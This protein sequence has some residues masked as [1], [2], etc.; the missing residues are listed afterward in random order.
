M[1]LDPNDPIVET[2]VFGKEVENFLGGNIGRYLVERAEKQAEE[3]TDLLKKVSPWRRRRIQQLQNRIAVA[4]SVQQWLA[5]AI[6]D[7][8]SATRSLEAND[9]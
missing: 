3:A 9:D 1:K 8:I 2:A 4:E 6:M 5:D 7:G